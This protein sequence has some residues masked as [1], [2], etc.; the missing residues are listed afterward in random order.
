MGPANSHFQ[1]CGVNSML[2]LGP[3]GPCRT[4]PEMV[5]GGKSRAMSVVDRICKSHMESASWPKFHRSMQ[6]V[7]SL[8][9]GTGFT[10]RAAW[11]PT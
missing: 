8:D 3:N 5:L 6:K 10:V 4:L 11:F 7:T 9:P 1:A 2:T